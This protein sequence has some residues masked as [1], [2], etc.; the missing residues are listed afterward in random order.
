MTK[1]PVLDLL[2]SPPKDYFGGTRI[3][4]SGTTGN[5]STEDW[6]ESD[7]W[8]TSEVESVDIES[9]D[10]QVTGPGSGDDEDDDDASAGPVVATASGLRRSQGPLPDARRLLRVDNHRANDRNHCARRGHVRLNRLPS[11]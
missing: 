4:Y 11:A 5:E 2:V 10:S 6:S 7:L 3:V 9:G 8:A 1:M